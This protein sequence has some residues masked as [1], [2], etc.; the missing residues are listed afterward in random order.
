M[1][2]SREYLSM[3]CPLNPLNMLCGSCSH[4][5]SSMPCFCLDESLGTHARTCNCCHGKRAV[6]RVYQEAAEGDN[7]IHA[8]VYSTFCYLWRT[9]VPSVVVMKPRSD[10]C[11]QCQQNLSDSEETV[12][13]ANVLEHLTIVKMER[14]LYKSKCEECKASIE[15]YFTVDGTFSPPPPN[16]KTPANTIDIKFI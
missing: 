8:V 11:W 3:P 5:P 12:A 1:V 10:L 16:S 6:W 9:L 13:I 4:T 15:A 14:S 2:T 7:T